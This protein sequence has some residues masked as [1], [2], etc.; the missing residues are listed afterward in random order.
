MSSVAT[1]SASLSTKLIVPFL[2]SVQSVFAMMVKVEAKA[3]RPF[4]KTDAAVTHDVSSIIGFSGEIVGNVVVSFPTTVAEKLA[5]AFAGT[6]LTVKDADFADALGELA[7]MI[8]GGAKKHLG[9]SA[10]ITCPSVIIGTGHHLARLR[11]VPCVVIPCATPVGD[12]AVEVNIKQV[13]CVK[14]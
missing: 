4:L 11:D 2:T 1:T 10:S 14:P 9:V 8:V 5:S 6:P 12:F 7:N 13:E 3:G